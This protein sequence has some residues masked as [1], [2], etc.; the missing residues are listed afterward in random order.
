[1][2]LTI[3]HSIIHGELRPWKLDAS[4]TKRFSASIKAAKAFSPV[5]NTE[6]LNQIT[7]LL[8]DY[9]SLKKSIAA[10]TSKTKSEIKPLLYDVTLPKYKDSI[11]QYYYLLITVENLRYYNMLLQQ[12]ASWTEL[13]DVRYQAGTALKNI[14][15]LTIQSSKELKARG[16][17]S[18]PDEHSDFVHYALHYLKLSLTQLYF[19]IQDSFKEKLLNVTT[20]E[21]FYILDLEEPQAAIPDLIYKG[22]QVKQEQGSKSKDKRLSFGFNI[23]KNNNREKL[24]SVI[25]SLCTQIELLKEDISPADM[26]IQLLLSNDI[27][28]G[29]VQIHLDC[30]NKNFRYVI[31]K[32]APH[33]S[34]LS[35]VNIEHSKSFYSK[36]GTLLKANN[37]SKAISFDPKEK[38]KIDN[39][40]KQMQ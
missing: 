34:S 3:F 6:L 39:I 5:T 11:T 22:S 33:F 25:N 10:N 36:R 30:D 26:L 13:A 15:A 8:Q 18:L 20:P 14:K 2:E 32:L 1:M 7:S 12:S 35:F 29:K 27:K 23:T 17:T 40:F 24:K 9:P 21:D 31:E 19:S 38:A 16:F 4:K 37:F 28:P